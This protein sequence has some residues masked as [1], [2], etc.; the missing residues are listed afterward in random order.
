MND[1]QLISE[2]SKRLTKEYRKGFSETNIIQMSN[3][4]LAYSIGQS[5]PDE[6]K[7]S[8]SHYLFESI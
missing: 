4:F 6:F 8:R 5:A 2:L 1:K 7:L 3:F